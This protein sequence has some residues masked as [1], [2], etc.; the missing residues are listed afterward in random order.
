[1]HSSGSDKN[2]PK[3]QPC[4]KFSLRNWYSSNLKQNAKLKLI[5]GDSRSWEE[6]AGQRAGEKKGWKGKELDIQLRYPTTPLLGSGLLIAHLRVLF[7]LF[8]PFWSKTKAYWKLN[9]S[10]ALQLIHFRDHSDGIINEN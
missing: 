10:V 3:Q 2:N 6:G 5:P 7:H 9:L 4:S 8:Q 1:M